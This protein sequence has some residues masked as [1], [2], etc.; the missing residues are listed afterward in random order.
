[1]KK[2]TYLLTALLLAAT[3]LFAQE[4]HKH[5]SP[6]GGEV[7][8]AGTGF[9]MEA[10]IRGGNLSVYLLDGNERPMSIAGA[11]STAMIQTADGKIIRII[12]KAEGKENFVYKL[13]PAIKYNKVIVTIKTGGKTASAAFD[14][15]KKADSKHEATEHKH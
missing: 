9:H 11:S 15:N 6:H 2:V 12:L 1:M 7:K 14:L 13:S 5:G 8:T 4:D 3:T 10:V